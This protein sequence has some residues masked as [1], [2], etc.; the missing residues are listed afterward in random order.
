MTTEEIISNTLTNNGSVPFKIHVSAPGILRLIGIRVVRLRIKDLYYGTL[1][2]IGPKLS[3]LKIEI[4]QGESTTIQPILQ[5]MA[6]NIK[7]QA[8]IVAIAILNNP[9]KIWCWTWLLK[10]FLIWNLDAKSMSNL[11]SLMLDKMNIMD[12]MKS[13]ISTGGLQ[14]LKSEMS[15]ENDTGEIIAPGTGSGTS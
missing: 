4:K 1:L 2:K 11:M 12:F 8:E 10:S 7:L 3:K 14:V 9:F 5:N 13:I 15:P 6:V